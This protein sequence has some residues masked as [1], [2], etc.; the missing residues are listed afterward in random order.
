[1]NKIKISFIV[2]IYN[3]EK[4]IGECLNSI[5]SQDVPENEYEVICVDDCSPDN[6]IHIVRVY[7]SAHSNLR[8]IKHEVNKGLGGARNTGIKNACGEYIWFIDSDD[9]IV[10][11]C[12]ISILNDLYLKPDTYLFNYNVF[13]GSDKT[14]KKTVV[15]DDSTGLNGIE[16]VNHFFDKSITYHLGYVWRMIIKKELIIDNDLKFPENTWGEDTAFF[17]ATILFSKLII[18][19]SNSFYNYR[20]N[21]DSVSSVLRTKKKAKLIMQFSF[22]SAGE[23]INLN[24]KLGN[25]SPKYVEIFNYQIKKFSNQFIFDILK[26]SFCEK[27]LFFKLIKD[28]DSS[29]SLIYKQMNTFNQIICKYPTLGFIIVTILSPFYLLKRKIQR[30]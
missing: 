5:Y 22:G 7:Q 1:M 20:V 25:I 26:T 18:S 10:V 29:F 8:L 19:K 23:L 16:F 30:K 28:N 2:P 14:I 21:P 13:N 24:K 12:L 17:P 9:T 11:N 27:W 4:F 3:V 6:S 15:F